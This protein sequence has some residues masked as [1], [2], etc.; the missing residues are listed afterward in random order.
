M[1]L[2]KRDYKRA[3]VVWKDLQKRCPEDPT[4]TGFAEFLPAEAKA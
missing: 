4:I 1:S 2:Q 3:M